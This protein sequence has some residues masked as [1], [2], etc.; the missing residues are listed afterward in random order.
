MNPTTPTPL[1]SA[2]LL[3]GVGGAIFIV[4]G[5]VHG[6]YTL[7]DL[8]RPRRLVPAE[9]GLIAAMQASPVRLAGPKSSMWRAWVGFNLSHSLGALV[10]GAVCAG[11]VASGP[12][13]GGW[14]PAL[15]GAAYFAVG[16]SC[17]FVIPNL[18]IGLATLCFV[19]A[20]LLPGL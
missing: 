8:R 3:Y 19:A 6:V 1:V 13:A 17:W 9:H 2:A 18:G 20:A 7:L 16:W 11:W 10:V 12:V 14:V 4:L 15:L 5:V